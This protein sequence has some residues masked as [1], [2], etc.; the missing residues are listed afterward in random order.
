MG[1]DAQWGV[2][3]AADVGANHQRNRI[4]IVGKMGDS[5]NDGQIAAEIRKSIIERS[6]GNK[7]WTKQTSESQGSSEQY[8]EMA[9]TNNNGHDN[10][11]QREL[12]ESA[13]P[14]TARQE[15]NKTCRYNSL[16]NSSSKDV[17][18]QRQITIRTQSE[19]GNI[20]N[21]SWWQ[22]EPSVGRVANG[23]AARVDRLKAIGNGQVPLCAATAWR[24]LSEQL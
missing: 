15:F 8:G 1:F 2:L 12:S 18:R 13:K 23:V 24:I 9:Y 7:S 14:T 10:K 20:S 17:E 11:E 5:N 6:Y 21:A 16:G 4:W 22:S 3:G 19:F